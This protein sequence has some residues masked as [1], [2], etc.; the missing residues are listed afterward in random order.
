MRDPRDPR[1]EPLNAFSPSYLNALRGLEDPPSAFEAETSGPFQIMESGGRYDLFRGW[2]SPE[3]GDAPLA[4]FVHR[5]TALLFQAVWPAAG[6]DRL[7]R[8]REPGGPEGF[9]LEEESHVV[10]RLPIYNAETVFAAHVAS[11]LTRTPYHLALLLEAAGP[12]A[13]K[14]IGAALGTRVLGNR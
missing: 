7:F 5:E 8:L 13:Q 6:R 10:G 1:R 9:A 14:L 12:V 3:R 2:E 11:Y 4:T